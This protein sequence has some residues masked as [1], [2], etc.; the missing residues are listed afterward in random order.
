[1]SKMVVTGDNLV[2]AVC[3]GVAVWCIVGERCYVG[4]GGVVVCRSVVVW[5]G[6][7]ECEGMWCHWCVG[8]VVCMVVIK[9]DLEVK[10]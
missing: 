9:V 6:V 1:M 8:V 10:N 2:W 7:Q 3:G 5:Y 4:D